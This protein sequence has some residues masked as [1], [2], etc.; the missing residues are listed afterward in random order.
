MNNYNVLYEIK[1]LETLIIRQLISKENC[2]IKNMPTPSQMQI[3]KYLIDHEGEDVFQKDLE[4]ILGL[5]RATVSGV[6]QTMEKNHLI[7]RKTD[8]IDTRTKKIILNNEAKA[9]FLNREK[10]LEELAYQIIK[11]IDEDD[12]KVLHNVL[13]KMQKNINNL[14]N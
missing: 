11:G 9:M 4:S 5:R 12:L 8:I 1:N 13:L 2:S 6:L 7:T 10:D 3:M 14:N